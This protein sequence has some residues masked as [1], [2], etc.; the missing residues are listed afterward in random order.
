MKVEG[1]GDDDPRWRRKVDGAGREWIE[2]VGKGDEVKWSEE[3]GKVLLKH[4]IFIWLSGSGRRF[5]WIELALASQVFV[6]Y[7]HCISDVL[8]MDL[9]K[10]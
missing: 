6:M 10:K 3:G 5:V 9:I 7:G 2:K 8:A 4:R 1:R